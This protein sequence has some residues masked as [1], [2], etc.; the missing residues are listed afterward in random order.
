MA[1]CRSSVFSIARSDINRLTSSRDIITW[2]KLS[3]TCAHKHIRALNVHLSVHKKIQNKQINKFYEVHFEKIRSICEY[4]SSQRY[5]SN[6][7]TCRPVNSTVYFQNQASHQQQEG[8]ITKLSC[9][10][11]TILLYL[12]R[13]NRWTQKLTQQSYSNMASVCEN[14]FIRGYWDLR[15]ATSYWQGK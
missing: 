13:G 7:F 15:L 1:F 8:G 5:M 9:C 2:H 4:F 3:R 14:T 11:P 6:T 12:E 10:R